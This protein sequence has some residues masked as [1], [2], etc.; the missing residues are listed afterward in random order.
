MLHYF[1]E[2]FSSCSIAVRRIPPNTGW[3]ISNSEIIGGWWTWYSHKQLLTTRWGSQVHKKDV[4]LVTV[5]CID[6]TGH[7]CLCYFVC[8]SYLSFWI[9]FR[10]HVFL[11]V[12]DSEVEAL[13]SV[14]WP[15]FLGKYSNH[16]IQNENDIVR[17]WCTKKACFHLFVSCQAD[18]YLN[19][20]KIPSN[21]GRDT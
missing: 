8:F 5:I 21:S 4:I 17:S 1:I 15:F 9:S 11:E 3:G 12:Q 2:M 18:T 13:A 10:W 20:C 16:H 7:G 6:T 14:T 19:Q